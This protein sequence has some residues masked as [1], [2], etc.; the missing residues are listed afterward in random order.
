MSNII[1]SSVISVIE[2]AFLQLV[3]SLYIKRSL[4]HYVEYLV[5]LLES[6]LI[7]ISILYLSAG[8]TIT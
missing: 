4:G 5:L 6:Y 1:D 7:T 8:F 2:T 3:T